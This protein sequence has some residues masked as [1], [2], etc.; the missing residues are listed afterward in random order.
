M[1]LWQVVADPHQGGNRAMVDHGLFAMVKEHV[2][3]GL[4]KAQ[5]FV[6]TLTAIIQSQKKT[7]ATQDSVA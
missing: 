3:P 7:L 2:I 1:L 5:A 4:I 6:D